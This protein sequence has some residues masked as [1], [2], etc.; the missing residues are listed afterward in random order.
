MLCT[1]RQPPHWKHLSP[2]SVGKCCV[3][4]VGIREIANAPAGKSYLHFIVNYSCLWMVLGKDYSLMSLTM[5]R[6][7]G[8]GF[9]DYSHE[10]W[11]PHQYYA[12]KTS[13]EMAL[14]RL[15][16]GCLILALHKHPLILWHF[17][18][19]DCIYLGRKLRC[20][21]MGLHRQWTPCFGVIW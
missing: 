13:T 21:H 7:G 4:K 14:R 3:S 12:C 6:E 16:L 1:G 17:L 19:C 2:L 8:Q 18:G 9:S 11:N 10:K 5:N 20:T 15:L